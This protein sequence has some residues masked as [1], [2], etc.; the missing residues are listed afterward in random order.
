MSESTYEIFSAAAID[1]HMGAAQLA[2]TCEILKA[3]I[4]NGTLNQ[5][6]MV[7]RFEALSK[8][9]MTKQ[10]AQHAVPIVDIFRDFVAGEQ[11]RAPS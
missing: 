8:D 10:G 11:R 3:L 1:G 6:D 5:G 7:A 2:V 4:N 9:L